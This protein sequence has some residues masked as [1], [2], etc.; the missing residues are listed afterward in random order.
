MA[1]YGIEIEVVAGE[2][3]EP[4]V[5]GRF[6]VPDGSDVDFAEHGR[7]ALVLVVSASFGYLAD[8]PFR[9]QVR[10]QDDVATDPT[11]T[12][13]TFAFSLDDFI[14]YDEDAANTYYVLMSIGPYLSNVETLEA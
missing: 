3:G 7:H 9:S 5:R 4:A 12:S 14:A 1:D 13:G 8:R 2:K 10:Y 6:S 11:G